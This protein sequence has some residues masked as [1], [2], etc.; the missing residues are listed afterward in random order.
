M[1]K[2]SLF[3]LTGI[4]N[5]IQG[6]GSGSLG[7]LKYS[8]LLSL[9]TELFLALTAAGGVCMDG[10]WEVLSLAKEDLVVVDR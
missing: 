3:C 8:Q 4:R 9:R 7:T 5:S 2:T 6:P 1:W 10:N